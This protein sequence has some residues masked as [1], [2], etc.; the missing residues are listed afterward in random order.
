MSKKKRNSESNGTN[1]LLPREI[2]HVQQ[3][4]FRDEEYPLNF[5][6]DSAHAGDH[7]LAEGT[8]IGRVVPVTT[9]LSTGKIIDTERVLVWSQGGVISLSRERYTQRYQ[10][11]R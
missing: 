9:D 7:E 6:F 3:V 8:L 5:L 1:N 10:P 11:L 4:I 2:A